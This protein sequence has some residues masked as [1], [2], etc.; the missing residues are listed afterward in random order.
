[1]MDTTMNGF[2]GVRLGHSHPRRLRVLRLGLP[3]KFPRLLPQALR[4]DLVTVGLAVLALDLPVDVVHRGD[5]R[6][7][8]EPKIYEKRAVLV[9]ELV[10]LV[11]SAYDEAL[12]V[13][14]ARDQSRRRLSVGAA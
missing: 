13:E 11:L 6:L 2:R 4:V 8:R 1:M 3:Q 5:G 12:V 14:P 9:R 10:A 7:Q